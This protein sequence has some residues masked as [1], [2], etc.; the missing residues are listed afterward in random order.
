[1]K[2]YRNIQLMQSNLQWTRSISRYIGRKCDYFLMKEANFLLQPISSRTWN[3]PERSSKNS[4]C[5]EEREK[6]LWQ[7]F[8]LQE[9]WN[10]VLESSH[11][12][13]NQGWSWQYYQIHWVSP[14]FPIWVF[15]PYLVYNVTSGKDIMSMPLW[16]SRSLEL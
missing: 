8:K 2:N 16:C 14:A 9:K 1:M 10:S 12:H 4:G 13:S 15:L 3:W 11:C 5:N 6:L 7:A